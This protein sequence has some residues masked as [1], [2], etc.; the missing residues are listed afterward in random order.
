MQLD[1]DSIT[2]EHVAAIEKEININIDAL[3]S[4][5]ALFSSIDTVTQEQFRSFNTPILNR[6]NSIQALEWIPRLELKNKVHYELQKQIHDQKDFTLKEKEGKQLV[7]VK[8]REVYYPVHYAVPI[9]GNESVIGY[10]LFSSPNRRSAIEK[11][12]A[13]KKTVATTSV[14]LMQKQKGVFI[15]CP[16]YKKSKNIGFA[17]AAYKINDLINR[18]LDDLSTKN[19]R[20][21]IHDLSAPKDKRLLFSSSQDLSKKKSFLTR[22]ASEIS[23]EYKIKVADR[24]WQISAKPTEEYLNSFPSSITLSLLISV[25]FTIAVI[26]F[27][28]RNFKELNHRLSNEFVLEEKVEIRTH[29]LRISNKKLNEAIQDI[30]DYKTALDAT[31]IVAITDTKGTIEYVND[32]F[33]E[34]SKYS[35][36]E[37]IGVNHRIVN[38]G[39]HDKSFWKDMWKNI[40]S[41]EIWRNEIR[42]KAKDNSYYWVDTTII[43]LMKNNKPHHYI[44]I[45]QDITEKK[46]QDQEIVNSIILSQEKDR[47]YFSEDLH[48]GLAQTLA[49]ISFQIQAIEQKFKANESAVIKDDLTLIKDY[50]LQGLESTKQLATEL[51]PRSMM[52][53]GLITCIQQYADS[54]KASSDIEVRVINDTHNITVN[55]EI[56]ITIYRC[57]VNILDQIT[58]STHFPNLNNI[59]IIILDNYNKLEIKI[60]IWDLINFSHRFNEHTENINLTE[61]QKR[62]ELQGGQ[63]AFE[64]DLSSAKTS[65]F[66]SFES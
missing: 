9:S 66:I 8:K 65:I 18:A 52:K 49:G 15:F 37:L 51:M 46:N 12:L 22:N 7:P 53:Y 32:K 39:Y 31:A 33:T 44:S 40:G 20:I 1:F 19:C 28:Y 36:S 27:L 4:I 48:E 42:N 30:A 26:Y 41:G 5:K 17:L 47:E 45:R 59:E 35:E 62:I 3:V 43:P 14:D 34:I 56:E 63:L 57:V 61:I 64:Q 16:V 29:D 50:V 38:S 58:S 2:K 13:S 23:S 11:S 54:V 10:D 6:I 55:K 25:L 24:T 60:E 21:T